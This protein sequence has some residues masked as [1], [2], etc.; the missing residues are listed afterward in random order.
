MN[1]AS[2][3][4]EKARGSCRADA[5]DTLDQA[6]ARL[7]R[8]YDEEPQQ[9][10][11][12]YNPD[13]PRGADGRW[14]A[15]GPV[16][17]PGTP[18]IASSAGTKDGLGAGK[19]AKVAR[20]MS[21]AARAASARATTG[22]VSHEEAARQHA[23]AAN[24]HRIAAQQS[25]RS[26]YREAHEAAA[27]AHEDVAR[28]EQSTHATATAPPPPAP[29]S[30]PV[31]RLPA[32][33]RTMTAR[34]AG[35]CRNCG[36]SFRAGT[37]IRWASGVGSAHQD[38]GAA[39]GTT[40]PR[41]T[42]SPTPARASGPSVQD[43]PFVT[44]RREEPCRRAELDQRLDAMVGKVQLYQTR[45]PQLR[46]GADPS[47]K[48]EPGGYVIVGAGPWRYQNAE[49]NE[50][51]GDMSGPNWSGALYMRR[52]TEQEVARE[53]AARYEADRPRRELQAKQQE[54]AAKALAA[55]T[56]FDALPEHH[57]LNSYPE[58]YLTVEERN[59][60]FATMQ[61][62]W[63]AKEYR[64]GEWRPQGSYV[65]QWDYHGAP[66]TERHEYVYDFD[67]PVQVAG[68]GAFAEHARTVDAADRAARE[69]GRPRR[70]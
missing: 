28:A 53:T 25:A 2:S 57:N 6:L 30:H 61:S 38:C 62:V 4:V 49:D 67:Q 70:S 11:K 59:S 44:Y 19:A 41:G 50:D 60:R 55:R 33:A 29:P 5:L 56:A 51:M 15:A 12:A 26:D 65:K 22:T 18:H 69:A 10:D 46:E 32:N 36:G 45:P 64:A 20:E 3:H 52:A 35:T 17:V 39:A 21:S 40:A 23:N 58:H 31:D 8:L 24:Q 54:E 1:L 37:T 43:A 63:E 48:S 66:V 68:N 47:N 27:K 14:G 34:F 9:V 16:H 13:Q 7:D 42:T